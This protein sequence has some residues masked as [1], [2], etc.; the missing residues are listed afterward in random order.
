M[1][2]SQPKSSITRKVLMALSGFFLL[3][4]LLQHLVIN[5]LS[6]INPDSFNEVSHF[7]GNN[8]VVQFLLQPVLLFGVLFHL[9]MGIYLELKNKAARP[10]KYA[11][12]KPSSNS[13][14]MSR[15]MV[16]TGIM[17]MLFLGLHF[18]DFWIPE[19]NVKYIVG[20]TSGLID[21][22][23]LES[24]FR[25][26]EELTHKFIDPIRVVLYVLSFVFLALHLLH[27]FQSAFQ[28]VGFRHNKYTPMIKKL[29]NAYAILVPLGFVLIAVVHYINSLSH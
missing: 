14:W 28:S 24:G 13:S 16:I 18:Y 11:Y 9:I 7:M 20:D 6:I 15:N 22:T 29:G 3:F 26:Y 8:P 25:Y 27:G 23:N 21:S 1:S 12:N 19:I 4:F 10:V 2:K 5:L 17:V